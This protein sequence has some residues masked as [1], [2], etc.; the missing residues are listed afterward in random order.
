MA[1]YS[2]LFACPVR[3]RLHDVRVAAGRGL[4]RDLRV[5][6]PAVCALAAASFAGAQT[7]VVF[8]NTISTVAGGASANPTKG[9]ACAPG[10]PFTATDALGDGCPATLSLL[11][12]TLYGEGTDPAGNIFFVD[13]GNQILHRVDAR[14]GIMTVVAG[15]A[16]TVGCAGQA[17][18]FGDNCLAATQT[19][20]FNN[21]RGM[22]VD[23]YGNVI[24][25]G[26]SEDLVQIVCNAVSPLCSPA[27]I[28]IM[29]ILAGY[30]A[31]SSASGT[32]VVGT[33]TA[34]GLT[35][36]AGDGTTA[37]GIST[38]GVDQPRGAAA[39][40]F[41]NVYIADTAN[42]R[43]RVVVGPASY[44]GV[45]NPL[46]AAIG[47]AGGPYAGVTG[48]TGAGKIYGILGG[49]TPVTAGNFCNGSSGAKSRWTPLWRR[50]S[51]FQHGSLDQHE[52]DPGR[53]D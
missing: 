25:A 42:V 31:S 49:F 40:V 34:S 53:G 8:P 43:F 50:L 6:L 1:I 19:G 44:N 41:G 4:W 22:S 45:T 24:I 37:V 3:S 5:A 7:P 32:A 39:D 47:L 15:G 12:T 11:G 21:P 35:G 9:A 28:G 2:A 17:D 51:L 30:S 13:T 20:A 23:P 38:T 26:Y 36:A 18:K 10:S 14:S 29:R 27:Q 33:G 46:A 16:T 48:A 52:F